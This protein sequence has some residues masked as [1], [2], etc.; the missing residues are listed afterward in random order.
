MTFQVTGIPNYGT[1]DAP[2]HNGISKVATATTPGA[3]T[4]GSQG[5]VA[6]SPSSKAGSINDD[7][8]D[9]GYS[10]LTPS[11]PLPY[12]GVTSSANGY[13]PYDGY[14]NHSIDSVGISLDGPQGASP[15]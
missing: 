3:T 13:V 14:S 5:S 6:S 10:T 7:S 15:S 1:E 2:V 9:Q 4:P 11:E 12:N 8:S